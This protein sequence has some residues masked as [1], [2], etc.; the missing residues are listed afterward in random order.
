MPALESTS[1][2]S[3][4]PANTSSPQFAAGAGI[5]VICA[6][7]V[8][9]QY[10]PGSRVLY[11]VLVAACIFARKV[12]WL[13]N[14]CLAA[15]LLFPVVAAIHAIVLVSEHIDEAVDMDV[16][17]AFQ[18]CAI[19]AL[20]GPVT[21][22][23]SGTYNNEAGRNSIF[24]WAM[25][26]LA[27]LLSLTVEF[28]RINGFRCL[29]DDAGNPLSS[30]PNLFPYEKASCGVICNEDQGPFS[31]LR[32]GSA[33]NI[34]L[35]P[36][37]TKLNF[38]AATL[39][40]AACCLPA[41]LLCVSTWLNILEINY[42]RIFGDAEPL[43]E[44]RG[45][46]IVKLI[47]RYAITVIFGGAV[48]TILVLGE[49]NLFSKEVDYQTE[50]LANVGQWAPIAGTGLA[51]LG[52][53]YVLLAE[54]MTRERERR[55]M[56]DFNPGSGAPEDK[57]VLHQIAKV[58]ISFSDHISHPKRHRFDTSDFRRGSAMNF[59]E[60][61]GESLR[62]RELSRT[63]STYNEYAHSS[64]GSSESVRSGIS[65]LSRARSNTM[66]NSKDGLE[67]TSTEM[68]QVAGA[69]DPLARKR[70]RRDTLEVPT[71]P[72][73]RNSR[74]NSLPVAPRVDS[75]QPAPPSSPSAPAIVVSSD[76]VSDED[77]TKR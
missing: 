49:R 10:G 42:K 7:P 60:I 24:V 41:I 40:S 15:A 8:S 64:R 71:S 51:V 9:G 57:G 39:L 55:E 74:E 28:Y 45:H 38:N 61:P 17:G 43:G 34:Y 13:R 63:R 12:E 6:W 35:I 68:E 67:R 1:T 5:D 70:T 22:R 19:G 26:I 66:S 3:E 53:V 69:P 59:P 29:E 18:F 36:A 33:K 25:L 20:V 76:T 47:R 16:Y 4:L 37:P 50:P 65:R 58:L 56:E 72:M 62:N 23:I 11:Y 44:V 32:G 21:V 77:V 31:P 27:G 75:E 46:F 14:A 54:A 73:F 52:S 48:L 30:N 2:F